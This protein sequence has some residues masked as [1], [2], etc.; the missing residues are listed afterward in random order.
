M[1]SNNTNESPQDFMNTFFNTT[2]D[3]ESIEH[4]RK[5]IRYIRDDIKASIKEVTLFNSK[6]M[7][8]ITLHDVSSH[9]ALI[10]VPKKIKFKPYQ[11]VRLI[12][13]FADGKSFDIEATVV[14]SKKVV[15]HQ[16][17]LTKE[18]GL[19]FSKRNNKLGD[20]LVKTQTD[21]NIHF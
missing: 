8:T 18:F 9:G 6:A 3:P 13:E 15:H 10:S 16:N 21:L 1:E 7:A 20:Y 4:K 19:K 12:L 5:S 11:K 17:I 14:H 2:P